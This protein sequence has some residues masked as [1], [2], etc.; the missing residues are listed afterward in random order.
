MNTFKNE[1]ERERYRGRGRKGGRRVSIGFVHGAK[2]ENHLSF[3]LMVLGLSA[4]IKELQ[5]SLSN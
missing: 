2:Q 4:M 5:K 1:V 3:F